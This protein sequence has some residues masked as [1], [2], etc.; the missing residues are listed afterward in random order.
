MKVLV[1]GASGQVGGALLRALNSIGH[2]AI[3]TYTSFPIEGLVPLNIED[4]EAVE[5]LISSIG[6]D[7]ILCPAG[8][9]NVDYCEKYPIDAQKGNMEYPM[10]AALFGREIGS[11][12]VYYSTEYV[13]DGKNGPYN[14]KDKPNPINHYG[15]SK[16]SAEKEI[17]EKL[18]RWL[19]IRTTVVYG[20]ER[21]QKNFVYQLLRNYRSGKTMN[22]PVDQI[23]S[24]TYNWD[25][26]MATIE[27]LE[28]QKHDWGIYNI[29]GPDILDR[30][31]FAC[32]A[33]DVF[34]IEKGF[35]QP[36]TTDELGQRAQRPL[37]AGLEID[38]ALSEIKTPLKGVREGLEAMKQELK[39]SEFAPRQNKFSS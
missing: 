17:M 5:E 25:L 21:Q 6:P 37:N 7:W 16:L 12:F 8:V 39:Y 38:K 23:S 14:E 15:L 19:I 36:V 31:S 34:G 27:L 11:G 10:K 2:D 35:L 28:K 33:C 20:P 18:K 29:A 22:V 3:G 4:S 30:Y 1:I 9:T 32:I 13:F 26:A 24:P